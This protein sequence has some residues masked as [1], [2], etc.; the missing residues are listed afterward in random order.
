MKKVLVLYTGGGNGHIVAAQAI[1]EAFVEKHPDVDIKLANVLDFADPIYRKVFVGG[2]DWVSSN[3]PEVWGK[4]YS[5][6]NKKEA[7]RLPTLISR[8]SVERKFIN[9]VKD[10]NPDFI[11]ST[12]PLPLVLVTASKEKEIIKIPSAMALTDLGCHS[13]WV[14]KNVDY[15]FCGSQEVLQC[16]AGYK[17]DPKRIV[18]SGIP[19]YPK[20][21]KKLDRKKIIEK[22]NLNSDLK[23]VLIVG[24]QFDFDALTS[25]IEGVK[26]KN[27]NSVQFLVVA[28]RDKDLEK[29]LNSSDLGQSENVKVY[30]FVD[31]MEEMMTA[32][33]L[34]FSKAGGLTVSECLAKGLPMV[35]N[36]VIPGQEEDNANYLVSKNAAVR[37]NDLNGIISSVNSLLEDPEKLESMHQSALEIGH[38]NS[39]IDLADFVMD[40]IK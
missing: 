33:D 29:S 20:F 32:A 2:Y 39:A 23:T 37:T 5:V 9:F 21:A 12:H 3:K 34:I 31:N 26:E 25:I 15:Y 38:P 8:M 6:L 28:G 1:K 35:I 36:K 13:F 7:Q 16:L 14:D 11:I 4:F 17:A 10:Y 22:L 18:V 30:G 19:V 27:N 40:K 24:G